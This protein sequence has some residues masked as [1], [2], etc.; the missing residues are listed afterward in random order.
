MMEQNGGVTIATVAVRRGPSSPVRPSAYQPGVCNIGPDEIARRR[1]LAY[2]GAVVTV[3]LIVG[4]L[5]VQA[6]PL[7]RFVL[8]GVAAFGTAVD[9]LQ[10]RLHFC[11]AFASRGVF[12]FGP[13][14]VVR[15]V[16][17]PAARARDRAQAARM[18][19]AGGLIGMLVGSAAAFLPT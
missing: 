10:V 16:A 1:R 8:V 14:G 11:V 19:V 5:A 18:L 15:S 13:L 3:A 17:G 12:N 7:V 4:L 2:L 6:P 9:Y